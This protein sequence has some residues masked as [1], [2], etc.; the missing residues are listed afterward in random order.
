M[1]RG[2]RDVPSVPI[3][4]IAKKLPIHT[5]LDPMTEGERRPDREVPGEEISDGTDVRC[6]LRFAFRFAFRLACR[7]AFR[8]GFSS[9]TFGCCSRCF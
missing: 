7:L 6:R 3:L 1:G 2:T 4:I 5:L 8:L 9:C